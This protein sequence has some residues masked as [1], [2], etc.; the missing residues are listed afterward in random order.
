M[1][2]VVTNNDLLFKFGDHNYNDLPILKEMEK[3]NEIAA[4]PRHYP[5]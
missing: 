1:E 4:R 3:V 2:V 5:A